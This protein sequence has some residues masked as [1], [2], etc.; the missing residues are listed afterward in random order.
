M[1]E[2]K[3]R[4]QVEYE[5]NNG[6]VKLNPNIVR[7]YLVHGKGDLVTD[8][9]VVM[10]MQQCRFLGMNPFLRDCYLIKYSSNDPATVVVGKDWF[11]KKSASIPSCEGYNAG[12]I[13][14]IKKGNKTVIERRIGARYNPDDKEA[15]EELIGGWATAK[16]KGWTEPVE[17]EVSMREYM[18][19]SSKGEPNRSW[20]TMPATM[21]R[22]VALVQA[23]REAFPDV[24]AGLYSP[25]EMPVDDSALPK[26]PV[27][28]PDAELP[29]PMR[30]EQNGEVFI[31]SDGTVV[32]KLPQAED[33]KQEELEIY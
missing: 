20:K 26:E 3:D 29:I 13:L 30:E 19:F 32:G 33:V 27:K 9:E 5:T 28:L 22:K 1:A 31:K 24:Y 7:R 18:R 15:N 11:L 10:Y 8:T 21:I 6:V 12:L 16:R 14:R 17:I 25:E 2:E 23:L 4:M